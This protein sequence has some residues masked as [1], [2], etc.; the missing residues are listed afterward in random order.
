MNEGNL[1]GTILTGFQISK[2]K[3]YENIILKD[4]INEVIIRINNFIDTSL[5]DLVDYDENNY[6]FVLKSEIFNNEINN[7]LKEMETIIPANIN[8]FYCYNGADDYILLNKDFKGKPKYFCKKDKDGT[9]YLDINGEKITNEHCIGKISWLADYMP[10][11]VYGWG[12]WTW[13]DESENIYN[14]DSE[15]LK[16]INLMKAKT[17]KSKLSKALIYY[18][19]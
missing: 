18:N 2:K 13:I 5:Y 8:Y 11:D 4:K 14:D 1:V 16:I 9:Y 7:L 10:V 17:Y 6:L 3:E 12:I 15:V 19:N